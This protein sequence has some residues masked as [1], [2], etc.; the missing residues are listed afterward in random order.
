MQQV[1]I[2][3][4]AKSS[5]PITSTAELGAVPPDLIGEFSLIFYSTPQEAVF[6]ELGEE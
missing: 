4:G 2:D 3:A 5:I 1:C 6:K